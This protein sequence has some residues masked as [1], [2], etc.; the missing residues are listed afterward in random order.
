MGVR[1]LLN[2]LA[3]SALRSKSDEHISP[4]MKTTVM[5]QKKSS[6][7]CHFFNF[8]SMMYVVYVFLVY[9]PL[10]LRRLGTASCPVSFCSHCGTGLAG[11]GSTYSAPGVAD[12]EFMPPCGTSR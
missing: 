7:P 5:A 9:M 10:G 4:R 8:F 2:T 11:N 6:H 12:K 3:T 1:R